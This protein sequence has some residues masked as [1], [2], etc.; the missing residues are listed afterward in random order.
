MARMGLASI[1]LPIRVYRPAALLSDFHAE[2]MKLRS[3]RRPRQIYVNAIEKARTDVRQSRVVAMRPRAS[4][5][6]FGLRRQYWS[7]AFPI[8]NTPHEFLYY[9]VGYAVVSGA[10]AAQTLLRYRSGQLEREGIGADSAL[11]Q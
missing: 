8:A 4:G 11:L 6:P 5:R 9:A 7:I 10:C 2:T 3:R 1:H